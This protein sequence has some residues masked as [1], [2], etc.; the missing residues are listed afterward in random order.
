M[1]QYA[2]WHDRGD[3][4]WTMKTKTTSQQWHLSTWFWG[5][6]AMTT[7]EIHLPCLPT[8]SATCSELGTGTHSVMFWLFLP[9]FSSGKA[10]VRVSPGDGSVVVGEESLKPSI[11]N[12]N[13]S[14][15]ALWSS[16]PLLFRSISENRLAGITGYK[17]IITTYNKK[18]TVQK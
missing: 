11:D 8:I 9:L 12:S 7:K 5:L 17:G 18:N 14:W 2:Q 10:G 16:R 4:S 3:M 13:A 15:S 1:L 6:A